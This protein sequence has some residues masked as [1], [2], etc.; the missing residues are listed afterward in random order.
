VDISASDGA[1]EETSGLKIW[2]FRIDKEDCGSARFNIKPF[3]MDQGDY[4]VVYGLDE[5]GDKTGIQKHEGKGWRDR[6]EV[7]T[8]R[9]WGKLLVLELH[10]TSPRSHFLLNYVHYADCFQQRTFRPQTI[11][12]GKDW[13][14]VRCFKSLIPIPNIVLHAKSIFR[15]RFVKGYQS[16]FCTAWKADRNGRF[17]TNWHCLGDQDVTSTAELDYRYDS[18]NCSED[19]GSS[20]RVFNA[21]TLIQTSGSVHLDFS[22]FTVKE[23]TSS[24][25]CLPRSSTPPNL[26][27]P[28]LIIHHPG[29]QLKKVSLFSD[30]DPEGYCQRRVRGCSDRPNDYC[31]MCDTIGGSSGSPVLIYRK[32]GPMS[33]YALHHFGGCP[34]SGVKMSL[35]EEAAGDNLEPCSRKDWE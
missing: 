27:D 20:K 30:K 18:K 10:V 35:I 31:Y 2:R 13:L 6:G 32:K 3:F 12:G 15:L 4:I 11:C 9:I 26:E 34:N 33:V 8:R 24:V 1:H 7:N 19:K 22:I 21:D 28:M 5:D 25:R 23:K 29:G 16:Y 14:N 17:L